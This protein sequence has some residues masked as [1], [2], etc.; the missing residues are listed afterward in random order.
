V[1][2]RWRRRWSHERR[3][4]NDVKARIRLSFT[5]QRTA[6]SAELFL[7]EL[8]GSERRKT[9]G[10]QAEATGGSGPWRQQAILGRGRWDAL[11]DPVRKYTL[12]TLAD[13]DAVL[14][15]DGGAAKRIN[16]FLK[17]SD[18]SCRACPPIYWLVR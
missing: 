12:E 5:Q 18:A 3:H 8:L 11:P 10:M 6:A 15:L 1:V 2:Y 4:R 14:V 17:K 13:A 9:G 7:D 16:G